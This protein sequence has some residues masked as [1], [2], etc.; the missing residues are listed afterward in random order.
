[1][2]SAFREGNADG[3]FEIALELLSCGRMK[4]KRQV[5]GDMVHAFVHVTKYFHHERLKVVA[6]LVNGLFVLF[7]LAVKYTSETGVQKCL[8][9]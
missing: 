6:E 2:R 8:L 1:M 3:P 9:V 7:D 5:I 4:M